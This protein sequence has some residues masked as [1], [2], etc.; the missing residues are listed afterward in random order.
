MSFDVDTDSCKDQMDFHGGLQS[1]YHL[2]RFLNCTTVGLCT[3]RG[4]RDFEI[5]TNFKDFEKFQLFD[6]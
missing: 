3:T 5:L 1:D 4:T 6:V 2:L